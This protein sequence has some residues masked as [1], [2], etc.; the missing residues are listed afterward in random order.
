M[1]DFVEEEMSIA[2]EKVGEGVACTK[3]RVDA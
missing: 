3:S 1:E 2:E